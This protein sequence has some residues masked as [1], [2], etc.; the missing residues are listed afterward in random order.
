MLKTKES[1][2]EKEFFNKCLL[3]GFYILYAKLIWNFQMNRLFILLV[4]YSYKVLEK[5][6]NYLE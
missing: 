2:L 6:S 5:C 3:V 1:V 4:L